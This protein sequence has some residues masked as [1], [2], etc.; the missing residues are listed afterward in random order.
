MAFYHYRYWDSAAEIAFME[1]LTHELPEYERPSC[2][3]GSIRG[4]KTLA[5][6]VQTLRL[7]VALLERGGRTWAGTHV[8]GDVVLRR[9]RELLAKF[10]GG[11][12]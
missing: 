2:I 7:Y 6:R 8:D 10:N 4:P 11:P 3:G 1:S 9:G 12:H 5:E